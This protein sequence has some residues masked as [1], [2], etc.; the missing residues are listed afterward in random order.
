[1]GLVLGGLLLA[2]NLR[3]LERPARRRARR[4]ARPGGW[5]RV[6]P[7]RKRKVSGPAG[8]KA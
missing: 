6:I 4:G 1:M 5:R 7:A 2:V 8:S 3:N